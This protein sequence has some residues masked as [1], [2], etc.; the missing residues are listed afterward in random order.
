MSGRVHQLSPMQRLAFLAPTPAAAFSGLALV[1]LAIAA[2]GAPW[3]SPYAYDVQDLSIANQAPSAL[4]WF[5]TDEFGRDILSRVIYGA[6]TSLSVSVISITLSLLGGILIGAVCGYIGGR[7]DRLV[8]S[9]VDLT[10]CFPEILLALLIVAI[11]GPGSGST[12]LAIAIAYLAQFTRLT[13][14]QI[15]TLKRQ[16][17]VEASRSMGAG[18]FHIMMRRLLPNAI[19]PVVVVAMLSTGN[20]ILLE[21]TL[22]FFGMGAQ[23]PVPSW[24]G[25]MSTGSAQLF[26]APW[27]ILWPGVFVAASVIF[28]NLFG[29]GVLKSLDVK[30]RMRS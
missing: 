7:F 19:A 25:M 3:I 23:P 11:L 12:I 8:M 20:A 29:Q 21:A 16:T 28:I 22:G 2:I 9:A 27:V 10:W 26:N 18:P 1:A 24:G 6:R 15:I 17:F 13:R 30:A 4:H 14:T 5:G